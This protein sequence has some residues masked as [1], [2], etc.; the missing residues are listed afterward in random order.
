MTTFQKILGEFLNS[1]I[2]IKSISRLEE[3]INLCINKNRMKHTKFK[4]SHHHILPKS[5]S[6]FPEFKNLKNNT[7]NGTYL[8]HSDHY[9]VH[10][11]MTEAIEDISQLYA[12]CAMHNKDFKSGKLKEEDLVTSEEFQKKMIV[13]NQNHSKYLQTVTESGLTNAQ[14]NAKK[15]AE[16][17]KNIINPETG[18]SSYQESGKKISAHGKKID[19][20][21]GLSN[22]VLASLKAA[23]TMSKINPET[24]LTIR[25]EAEIKRQATIKRNKA[26]KNLS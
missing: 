17:R 24:G 11:L 10:W 7:W 23:Q 18:L 20:E 3:Y 13:K 1:N 15:S 8:M 21:T 22:A 9:N 26:L 12:F 25:Q 4:T 6:C 5:D 19:S 2:K 14:I 16:A